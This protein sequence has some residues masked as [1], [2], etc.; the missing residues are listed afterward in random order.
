MRYFNGPPANGGPSI[1]PPP[2]KRKSWNPDPAFATPKQKWW[3]TLWS[4]TRSMKGGQLATVLWQLESLVK[5]TKEIQDDDAKS[6]D[7]G[8]RA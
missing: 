2:L 3:I 5:Q 1:P 6:E 7:S 8:K 4:L